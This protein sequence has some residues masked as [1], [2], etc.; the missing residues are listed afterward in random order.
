MSEPALLEREAETA[1]VQ[2]P[3]WLDWLDKNL[4]IIDMEGE[5]VSLRLNA[6]QMRLFATI[7]R[8]RKAGKPVRIIIL[9]GRKSGMSTGVAARYFT[10]VSNRRNRGAFVCAHDADSSDILFRMVKIFDENLPDEEKKD[11]EYSS[12]KEIVWKQP[13]YSSYRVQTAGKL[14]LKRGDT[15]FYVHVSELAFYPDPA[16]TLTALFN[17][18]AK[19]KDTMIVIESTANGVGGEFYERWGRAVARLVHD[20]NDIDGFMPIFISWLDDPQNRMKPS[21]NYDWTNVDPELAEDEGM[22]AEMCDELGYSD[23]ERK[24]AL[25]FRRWKTT[26]D[27]NGDLNRFRQEYPS[28]P[29]EAFLVSGRPAIP[30]VIIKEHERHVKPGRRCQLSYDD[31]AVVP[32]AAPLWDPGLVNNYWEVWEPP[33][34]GHDYVVFGDVAEGKLTDPSNPKSAADRHAGGVLERTDRKLVAVLLSPS[35]PGGM[36]LD[37]DLFGVELRKAAMWYNTAWVSPEMNSC[38]MAALSSLRGYPKLFLRER[39]ADYVGPLPLSHYGWRTDVGNRD[40]MID[41]CIAACRPDPVVGFDR[42]VQHWCAELLL[43]EKTFV[44]DNNGKR[45]HRRG[46]HD[47]LWMMLCGL[48]QLHQRCPRSKRSPFTHPRFRRKRKLSMAYAGGYDPGVANPPPKRQ[49]TTR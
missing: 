30:S 47:D 37:P 6:N 16:R 40:H 15:L 14:E 10:E 4:V 5:L 24:A 49:L 28:T 48:I 38:G 42:S 46:A 34:P 2:E 1:A 25:Y 18:M 26:E 44:I 35:R 17:A 9:K 19:T 12:K 41:G 20:P 39:P 29:E 3:D 8:Q 36:P 7:E 23:E 45:Q 43:D 33:M 31:T 13:H 11:H 32:F 27:L 21:A 22:L